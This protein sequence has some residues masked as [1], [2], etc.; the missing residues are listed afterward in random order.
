MYD[1]YGDYY[2]YY[3]TQTE[4]LMCKCEILLKKH[5]LFWDSILEPPPIVCN[6]F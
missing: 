4:C 6:G 3:M 5:L 2:G 1:W